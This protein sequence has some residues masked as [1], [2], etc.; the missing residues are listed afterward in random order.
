M[1]SPEFFVTSLLWS[2]TMLD[3]F[4]TLVLIAISEVSIVVLVVLI[5]CLGTSVARGS[6]VIF[7]ATG[8]AVVIVTFL[9]SSFSFIA[10]RVS[11]SE[12][13][14]LIIP[15]G[16]SVDKIPVVIFSASGIVGEGLVTLIDKFLT[17]LSP[18][19]AF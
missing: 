1:P 3:V 9:I 18:C 16:L 7:F 12:P 19:V 17:L 5:I 11:P 8:I 14:A 4:V 2:T 13:V 15:K 10:L 6:V